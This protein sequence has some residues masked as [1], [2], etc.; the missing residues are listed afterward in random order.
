LTARILII[1]KIMSCFVAFCSYLA[2]GVS[3][4]TNALYF[5]NSAHN[6]FLNNECKGMLL[7]LACYPGG[8]YGQSNL[9]SYLI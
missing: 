9:F 6:Y 3:L 1:L 5:S 8:T 7:L 4:P 2:L